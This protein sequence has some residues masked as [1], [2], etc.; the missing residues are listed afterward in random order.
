[1]RPHLT[2]SHRRLPPLAQGLFQSP[3]F[4]GVIVITLGLQAIIMNFL[5]MFF[6]VRKTC[7][8]VK[9]CHITCPV[10]PKSTGTG[11]HGAAITRAGVCLYMLICMGVLLWGY[12]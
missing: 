3:I 9:V 11:L 5:G 7:S 10:T 2:L 1:M 4:V 8:N 12:L 6:K